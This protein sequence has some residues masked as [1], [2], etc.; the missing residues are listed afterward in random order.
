MSKRSSLIKDFLF[1]FLKQ[2]VKI[3][4]QYLGWVSPNHQLEDS[5][6]RN[7]AF[8]IYL[9]ETP[10]DALQTDQTQIRQLL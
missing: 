10:F 1:A 2:I 7:S 8:N 5:I 6:L 4:Y 9:I 3:V